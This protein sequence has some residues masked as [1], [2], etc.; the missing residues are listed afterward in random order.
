MGRLATQSASEPGTDLALWCARK[1]LVIRA[2]VLAIAFMLTGTPGVLACVASCEAISRT[3]DGECRHEKQIE[4]ALLAPAS[5]QCDTAP[6][7]TP[8]LVETQHR[9]PSVSVVPLALVSRMQGSHGPTF[10]AYSLAPTDSP[11]D[12]APLSNAL[13][14]V[15]RI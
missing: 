12:R 4:G 5:D 14:T 9:A 6:V 3:S 2:I 13:S 11:P 7:A 1:S 15:L 10:L 8:F